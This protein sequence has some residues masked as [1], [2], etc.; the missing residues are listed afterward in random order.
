M[1]NT[2]Q[3]TWLSHPMETDD[4]TDAL[5]G[6]EV[7]PVDGIMHIELDVLGYRILY[8]NVSQEKTISL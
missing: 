3:A 6:E 1:N 4:W 8:R 2:D 5:S 7:H